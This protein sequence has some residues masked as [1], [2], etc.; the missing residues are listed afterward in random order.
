VQFGAKEGE[1]FLATIE[2]AFANHIGR[3]W[4]VLPMRLELETNIYI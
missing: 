1:S 3:H 4:Q 2:A